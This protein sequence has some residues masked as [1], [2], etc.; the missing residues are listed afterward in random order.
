MESSA[1]RKYSC[2]RISAPSS[3]SNGGVISGCAYLLKL[4]QYSN[5]L[6]SPWI[7]SFFS[8]AFDP[9]YSIFMTLTIHFLNACFASSRMFFANVYCS[10]ILLFSSYSTLQSS[11]NLNLQEEGRKEGFAS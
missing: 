10:N 5:Q 8:F 2:R 3:L 1:V 9:S 11:L 7:N 4:I 6:R